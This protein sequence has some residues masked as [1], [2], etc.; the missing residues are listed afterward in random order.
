MLVEQLLVNWVI[1]IVA[2]TD[3]GHV[4]LFELRWQTG[5]DRVPQARIAKRQVQFLACLSIPLAA[6]AA[7]LVENRLDETFVAD[8][9]LSAPRG[10]CHFLWAATHG[11]SNNARGDRCGI[12]CFM[13][14]DARAC[15]SRHHP[16]EA[17]HGL[18]ATVLLVQQL[19][20]E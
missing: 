10:R 13:T 1:P 2:S 18:H 4:R 7:V 14:A 19:K 15:L 3:K 6:L 20:M 12:P 5:I 16:G 9:D 8:A 11:K 17:A